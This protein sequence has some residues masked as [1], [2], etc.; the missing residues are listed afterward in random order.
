MDIQ[1]IYH[2]RNNFFENPK[3]Y[4]DL[5]LYQI[6]EALCEISTELNNH[7]H[8]DW[9]E[10]SYVL[11]GK[12]EIFTNN[13]GTP[14]TK[15]D[16]YFSLPKEIHR[17]ASDSIEP[18]RYFFVAFNVSKDSPLYPFLENHQ[19]LVAD[20]TKRVY[21]AESISRHFQHLLF[22]FKQESPL[23]RLIFEYD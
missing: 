22:E 8:L 9:Y 14:V 4:N 18:L 7:P 2:F 19:K 17:I 10:F 3:Y 21:H 16:L 5:I 23:N 20:E 6:G 15:G 1:T 11:S 12:G 13:K